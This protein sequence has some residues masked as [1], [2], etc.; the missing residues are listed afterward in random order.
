MDTLLT[1]TDKDAGIKS[2]GEGGRAK[3]SA[4]FLYAA[5]PNFRRGDGLL[6][7]P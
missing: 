1:L 7:L 4:R 2:S 6:V 5:Q 3:H